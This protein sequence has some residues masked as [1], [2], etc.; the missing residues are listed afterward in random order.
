MTKK[1][2][3]N[4]DSLRGGYTVYLTRLDTL[5]KIIYYYKMGQDFLDIQ[6]NTN[7]P[8]SCAQFS[9]FTRYT[10]YPRNLAWVF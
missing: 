4:I 9:K 8:G 5:Y 6:Y 7:R 2:Q 10:E 3:N 1:N